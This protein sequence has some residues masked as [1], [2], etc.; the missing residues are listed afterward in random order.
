MNYPGHSPVIAPVG[1]D[2]PT[3]AHRLD[4]NAEWVILEG[5]TIINSWNGIRVSKGHN[6]IRHNTIYNNY[7]HGILVRSAGDLLIEDNII[8]NNGVGTDHHGISLTNP[9]CPSMANI[10]IRQ[11]TISNSSSAGLNA[12]SLCPQA[13]ITHVLIENNLF[14]N[15]SSEL[16]FQAG[17]NNSTIRN[18]T[19]VHILLPLAV[20]STQAIFSFQKSTSNVVT[21]NIIHAESSG[22]TMYPLETHDANDE[23][24]FDANLWSIPANTA[25]HWQGVLHT[26]FNSQYRTLT[27][28]DTH[29][30]F[31]KPN[32]VDLKGGDYHLSG[33]SPARN[34]GVGAE[35]TTIDKEGT[36]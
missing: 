30:L 18:N 6:T 12:K 16:V 7:S 29:G 22:A 34:A 27:G 13:T 4:M 21:N 10:T 28:Y 35:C 19:I 36:H 23:Q 32:F 8:E 20:N 11:N 2:L 33:L 15:N 5:F 17:V 31:A 25:W 14:E 1:T 3:V 24:H 9:S 26:D